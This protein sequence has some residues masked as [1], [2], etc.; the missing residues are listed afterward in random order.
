MTIDNNDLDAKE[1]RANSLIHEKSPYLLQHAHN[2]VD[3]YGWGEEAFEKARE[4]NKPIFLSIGY[5]TCH[6]CHVMEKESFE[7]PEVAQLLN[8]VFVSIKVD[9]EE[10]PDLD[11]IYMTVCRMATGGGGWPLTIIMT[12][13]KKPFFAA[14]YIPKT[15]RYGRAG[16]MEL[17]PR[18]EQVWKTRQQEVLESATGMTQALHHL[19]K[20][21]AVKELNQHTLEKAFQEL[22]KRFD[23]THGGFSSSPKFPTPH[24]LSF[25]LRHWK[26]TGN[27]EALHM[28]EMTLQKLRWGGIFD[29][30]GYGFH[31][32]STDK[33][34]LVPH[35]EKML[36]DQAMLA[37]AYLETYQA[38][39]NALYRDVAREVFA[40]V[41]RDMRSPEGGFY[42]AEDADSEGVEGKFYLWTEEELTEILSKQEA[43]LL[44]Q[45]FNV[46]E[47]GNFAEEATGK[48]TGANILYPGKDP[49]AISME[50]SLPDFERVLEQARKKLFEAREKRVHPY[51]D[52]KILTDWNGLMIAALARGARVLGEEQ[53]A[54][55]ALDAARFV[56]DRMCTPE[57]RLLH[58]YRE[59]DAAITA[60]ADDYAFFI[61]GLL[62][63][64]QATFD[65][66]HLQ[67]ALS[68]SEGLISHYWDHQGGGLFFTPDDGEDLII[69][70]KE[71][72]DGATPSGN[73]VAAHNFLRLARLT[74]NTEYEE[75]AHGIL[76][77]F[78]EQVD[79][80][81]SGYTQ[82]LC[83]L[84]FALGP[85]FEVVVAG[86]SEGPDVK[87]MLNALNSR[88]IPN[89]VALFR[90]S[91]K[92]SSA[93]DGVAEFIKDHA[94]RE[95][96]A[97]AYVCSNNACKEP[98][99]DVDEM[100][101]LML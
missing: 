83:S 100:L 2:P 84:D 36:Y 73:G 67:T 99:T 16:M 88:F 85:C 41:L 64:Y 54:L 46:E 69:R 70:K 86:P 5:S 20:N 56:L 15:S 97:T 98:T 82:F 11:H 60:N 89:H 23:R 17:I 66:A 95:G 77:S 101:A 61:W 37:L 74:G 43:E 42:S 65:A 50:L 80:F 38:T 32:Y 29:Q 51:K 18:V 13:D 62:E 24:N 9:R 81:P 48:L 26:R 21:P 35:F 96:K 45:A 52:D 14:T 6:W 75:K 28:V 39:G 57:G 55:A 58:R 34:W 7:D 31:R 59:G 78:S 49:A 8:N 93:I 63:L 68:L 10:R 53:Y 33:E 22:S 19:E 3:W 87:K 47:R 76:K 92:D 30:I 27:A 72:Y 91:D 44:I 94:A 4:E 79:E 40:Y 90:P 71:I 25:L 12:P 1:R